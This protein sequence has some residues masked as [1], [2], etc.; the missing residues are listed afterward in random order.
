MPPQLAVFTLFLQRIPLPSHTD[1][2]GNYRNFNYR[3]RTAAVGYYGGD[4]A[5][6][7]DI[8]KF[9]PSISIENAEKLTVTFIPTTP[10]TTPPPIL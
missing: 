7:Q 6:T 4:I 5:Q 3:A 2:N 10:L 9:N 8:S 1:L